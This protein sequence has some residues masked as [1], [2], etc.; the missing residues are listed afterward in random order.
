MLAFSG[1]GGGALAPLAD[2][3]LVVPD[4]EGSAHVQEAH[5]V[6]LHALLERVEAAFPPDPQH[7]ATQP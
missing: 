3:A 7:P 4:A 2:V 1:R 5:Q 6:L